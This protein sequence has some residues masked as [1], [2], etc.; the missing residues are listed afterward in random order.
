MLRREL[1]VYLARN[2][3]WLLPKISTHLKFLYGT[4]GSSQGPFS[5]LS[6]LHA[7]LLPSFYGDKICLEVLSL[8]WALKITTVMMPN[9]TEVRTR[10]N[11]PLHEIDMVLILQK[12]HY[13]SVCK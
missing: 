10:H 8:M 2:W 12:R 6:Y 11:Q 7:L 9:L 4:E 13:S 3:A 5:Y 1:V